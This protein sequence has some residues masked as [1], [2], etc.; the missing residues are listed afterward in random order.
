MPNLK[1]PKI[2]EELPQT[3]FRNWAFVYAALY[4]KVHI[5]GFDIF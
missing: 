3:D 4:P 1:F 2:F 5:C